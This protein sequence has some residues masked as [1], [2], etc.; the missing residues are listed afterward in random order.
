MAFFASLFAD[1]HGTICNLSDD[2]I[3]A[4]LLLGLYSGFNHVSLDSSS[5]N[6][7]Q[8]MLTLNS[9]THQIV[10]NSDTVQTI[11][12]QIIHFS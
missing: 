12:N 5:F 8:P 2:S 4:S 10:S 1:R 7:F 3:P 6:Q 11:V 9:L